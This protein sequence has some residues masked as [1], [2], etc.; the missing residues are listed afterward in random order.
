MWAMILS[1]LDVKKND[2]HVVQLDHKEK[3]PYIQLMKRVSRQ[4]TIIT[5]VS[6]LVA[7]AQIVDDPLTDM[8][9]KW[10]AVWLTPEVSIR[11]LLKFVAIRYSQNRA[12]LVY[13][14]AEK[15]GVIDIPLI[16]LLTGKDFLDVA[17][18]AQLGFL[19]KKAYQLQIDEK[20]VDRDVLKSKC[21]KIE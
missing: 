12:N 3:Q 19:V 4:D 16:P 6:K 5:Q 15:L 1:F 18:G 10:L 21:L 11:F 8:Q 2:Q 20:I 17:Q 13:K 14:Q 9:L 7:Y